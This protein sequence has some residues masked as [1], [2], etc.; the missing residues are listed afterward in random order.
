MT[1]PRCFGPVT[2]PLLEFQLCLQAREDVTATHPP[3]RPALCVTLT[4]T[5]PQVEDITASH[6]AALL[7][8]ENNHTVAIAILQGDHDLKVQGTWC[9]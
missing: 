3:P 4:V 7:E 1:R 8:M 6:E 9:T 2:F 5:V